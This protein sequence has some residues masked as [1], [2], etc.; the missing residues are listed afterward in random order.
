MIR[1]TLYFYHYVYADTLIETADSFDLK[2]SIPINWVSTQYV[3]NFND[4]NSIIN[5]MFL[6]NNSTEIDNYYIL[7]E[8]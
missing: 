2:L 1:N 8:L 5:L 3:D 4:S 7:P 6:R